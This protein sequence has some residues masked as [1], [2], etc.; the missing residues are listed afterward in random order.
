MNFLTFQPTKYNCYEKNDPSGESNDLNSAEVKGDEDTVP[1][2]K[3]RAILA[4]TPGK[5]LKKA[6]NLLIA[7]N[8]SAPNNSRVRNII[9]IFYRF[10]VVS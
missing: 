1:K 9:Y 7:E 10:R 8:S 3:I 5:G 6:L 4:T 2:S